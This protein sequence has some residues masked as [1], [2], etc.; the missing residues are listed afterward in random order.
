M[1][2]GGKEPPAGVVAQLSLRSA[3]VTRRHPLRRPLFLGLFLGLVFGCTDLLLTWLNPVEDDSPLV[4]LRFYGPMFLVWT[5]VS[6]RAARQAGKW[7]PGVLAGMTVAFATFSIFVL[8]NFLRVNVF[9]SQLTDRP[10]WQDMMMRF[11]GSGTD[12][13]RLFVNLDYLAG[14]P[15]KIAA[16]TGFGAVFGIVGGT[17]SWLLS[18]RARFRTV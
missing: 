14:T 15:F 8:L 16:A 4:L 3:L 6:F 18:V 7:W 11:R 5:V 17:V 10:D 13:L 12:S 9:L 1:G 2:G